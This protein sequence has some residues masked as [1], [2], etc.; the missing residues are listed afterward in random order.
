[1]LARLFAFALLSI[2]IRSFVGSVRAWLKLRELRKLD[3]SKRGSKCVGLAKQE[4]HCASRSMRLQAAFY[5]FAAV[6]SL[7]LVDAYFWVG[8]GKG[9]AGWR[10]L[11]SMEYVFGYTYLC[12]LVFF[13]V[14]VLQWI[15]AARVGAAIRDAEGR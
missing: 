8:D 1:M 3:P 11:N 5:L 7:S 14:H 13:L 4:R 10:V 6:V 12:S 9:M 15:T 2:A